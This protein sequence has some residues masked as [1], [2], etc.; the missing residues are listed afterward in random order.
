MQ[1][2]EET[3]PCNPHKRF[4][5][6]EEVPILED[7]NSSE[8]PIDPDGKNYIVD[9]L[10]CILGLQEDQEFGGSEHMFTNGWD[11]MTWDEFSNVGPKEE[12]DDVDHDD[13]DDRKLKVED[14]AEECDNN[15]SIVVKREN[16]GFWEEEKTISLNLNYQDVLDAWSDG[17]SPWADDYCLSTSND[18]FVCA[19]SSVC[20]CSLDMLVHCVVVYL[21]FG[22]CAS[23]C[24]LGFFIFFFFGCL[25]V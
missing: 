13:D 6:E 3:V 23:S 17:R 18:G 2:E 19:T 8:A 20:S 25:P 12:C 5:K 22:C 15:G 16:L 10:E 14:P 9:G 24:A 7:G 21:N 4:P 11:F 1:G